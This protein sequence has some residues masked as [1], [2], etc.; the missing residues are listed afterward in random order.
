MFK[1][2]VLLMLSTCLGFG[3]ALAQEGQKETAGSDTTKN[4]V[5]PAT[6]T[7]KAK[8]TTADTSQTKTAKMPAK[9]SQNPVVVIETNH[10]NFEVELFMKESPITAKNFLD[11]VNKGFYNGLTFHRIVPNFVIQGGDPSGDG[12][13]GPGYS[14]PDEKSTQR[15]VRGTLGMAKSGPNTTGSQF[16][17]NLKDNLRLDDAGFTA[18]AKVVKGME[19]VDKIGKLKNSGQPDNKALEKVAMSKVYVKKQKK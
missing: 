14:I 15:Q 13:G 11:L 19:V 2:L 10:G 1:N 17:V 6:D 9:T 7:L 3:L 18:F 5:T 12:S 4:K 8:A 16:Y